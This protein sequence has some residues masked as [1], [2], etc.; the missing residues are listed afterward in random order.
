M[1]ALA[2][3]GVPFRVALA[4]A[5]VRRN[6]VEFETARAQLGDRV[7]HYGFVEDEA[8]Y[9]RLLWEA[10]YAVSTAH[11]DFFGMAVVEAMYCGCVPILPQRLNYPQLLPQALHAR[12]LYRRERLAPLLLR[13]LQG[14]VSTWPAT[15][16][17]PAWPTM[18]GRRRRRSWIARWRNWPDRYDLALE[19]DD[20][21]H[22]LPGAQCN[23][24]VAARLAAL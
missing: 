9:A 19:G 23:H 13:H 1:L 16:C 12:C 8:A 24:V 18:T 21:D 6:P 4:G 20:R 14:T 3:D 15:S 5:N 17:A 11:Q 10:D 7:I 2:A 22:F